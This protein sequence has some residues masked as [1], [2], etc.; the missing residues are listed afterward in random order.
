[1]L[2]DGLVAEALVLSYQL[3]SDSQVLYRLPDG[4]GS[5]ALISGL[6]GGDRRFLEQAGWRARLAL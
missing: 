1:M 6:V 2:R 3:G 4:C 5:L